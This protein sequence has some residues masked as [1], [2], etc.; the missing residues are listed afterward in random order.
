[1]D[2]LSTSLLEQFNRLIESLKCGLCNLKLVDPVRIKT[3]GHYFC[4]KCLKA[5]QS[6]HNCPK[7]QEFYEVKHLDRNNIAKECEQELADLEMILLATNNDE[8]NTI[9]YESNRFQVVF[10]SVQVKLNARGETPL[11][12]ACKKNKIEE[13]RQLVALMY[14][15]NAKDYAGWAPLHEAIQSGSVNIVEYLLKQKCL[16]NIPGPEYTTPLHQAASL[17]HTQIVKLLLSY[18]ADKNLTDF[19]GLKPEDC[20]SNKA[21][22][23]V[24]KAHNSPEGG[25]IFKVFLPQKVV[26]YCHSV[27]DEIKRKL[28]VCNHIEVVNKEEINKT[29]LTHFVIK[30]SHKLSFKIMQAMLDGLQFINEDLVDS[31]LKQDYFINIPKQTFITNDLLNKGIQRA[32]MSALL[33]LPKLFDG[34]HFYIEDHTKFVE[35]YH[36]KVD[37]EYLTRLIRAGGGRVLNRAPAPRVTSATTCPFFAS[38]S[39]M[40]YHC[41]NFIIFNENNP[42]GLLYGMKE[43]KHKSSKWL[44]DCIVK[45]EITD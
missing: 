13:T 40:V 18:G 41:C 42:P 12:L 45:Y 36:L 37:K 39:S 7:C 9:I 15:V 43:L 5:S 10:T 33:K 6:I 30:K 35:V 8:E 17:N 21:V 3:C 23:N 2:I 44:I 14:D 27:D 32:M 29:K 34:V 26:V 24:L 25:H 1:M 20:T 4:L 38:K 28:E 11:H 22:R 19:N 16:V 31:F